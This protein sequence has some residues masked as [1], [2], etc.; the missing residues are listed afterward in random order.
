MQ[1]STIPPVAKRPDNTQQQGEAA[2]TGEEP[3]FEEALEQVERIIE[4]IESG[5]I[6]LEASIREYERGARLLKT[7]R[8]I[9]DRAERRIEELNSELLSEGAD[10]SSDPPEASDEEDDLVPF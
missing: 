8:G 2:A 6:G 4:R 7:C 3:S 1:R 5:Q 9:L 10:S